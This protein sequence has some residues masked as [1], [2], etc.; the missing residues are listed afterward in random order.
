MVGL[1]LYPYYSV[2][3]KLIE[4]DRAG[5]RRHFRSKQTRFKEEAWSPNFSYIKGFLA[6]LIH[7][8]STTEILSTVC[9]ASGGLAP[10]LLGPT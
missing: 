3:S 5:H 1:G 4:Q 2:S 7:G 9:L 10:Y 8:F 6:N